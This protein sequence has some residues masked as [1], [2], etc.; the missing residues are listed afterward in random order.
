MIRR[1]AEPQF[2]SFAELIKVYETVKWLLFA[3]FCFLLVCSTYHSNF[4][5]LEIVMKTQKILWSL[6]TDS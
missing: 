6:E 2:V 1:G 3:L 4:W 5:C